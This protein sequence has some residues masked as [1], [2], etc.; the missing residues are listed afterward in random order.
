METLE[1]IKIISLT[2]PELFFFKSTEN[3]GFMRDVKSILA[4]S[5]SPSLGRA[6][7]SA[8]PKLTE[9]GEHHIEEPLVFLAVPNAF[10]VF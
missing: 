10:H 7:G 6:L 8:V 4:F 9:E 5:L 1:L 3:A 2:I